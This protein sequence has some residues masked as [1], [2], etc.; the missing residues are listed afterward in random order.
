MEFE[1]SLGEF[2]EFD[3]EYLILPD[4]DDEFDGYV[5]P[6]DDE[7]VEQDFDG[8]FLPEDDEAEFEEEF[9]DYVLQSLQQLEEYNFEEPA[10]AAASSSSAAADRL[11]NVVIEPT[12]RCKTCTICLEELEVGGEAAAIECSHKFHRDCLLPWLATNPTCPY[13]RFQLL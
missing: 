10:A 6:A 5:L 12:E 11:K 2:V 4:D 8:Y 13:C 7:R 3:G 1:F 9:N